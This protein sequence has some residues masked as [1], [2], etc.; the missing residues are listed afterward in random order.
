MYNLSDY[1]FIDL[2]TKSGGSIEFALRRLGGKRGLGI[3]LKQENVLI[4]RDNGYDCLQGDATRLDFPDNSFNFVVMSHFLEH[5]PDY[6]TVEKVIKNCARIARD[7]IYIQ[8]P[9]FDAD[10]YLEKLGLK[11]Y[12]SDWRGHPA[13][14]KTSDLNGILRKIGIKKYVIKV[15]KHIKDSLNP[16]VHPLSSPPDQH[17]YQIGKHPEKPYVKFKKP[18]F[19]E[20]VYYIP[21]RKVDNW[22]RITRARKGAYYYFQHPIMS[23]PFLKLINK[24]INALPR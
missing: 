9:F 5:L 10:K 13:K 15:R 23:F 8:G 11:L 2:G 6:E 18:I 21:L 7:F 20:I 17:E 19:N 1:D 16:A 14:I 4:A 12:W 24:I 3:D 22:Y